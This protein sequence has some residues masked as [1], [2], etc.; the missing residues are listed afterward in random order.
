VA[1]AVTGLFATLGLVGLFLGTGEYITTFVAQYVGARRPDRIGPAVWQGVYF[2][3]AAG[4]LVAGLTP[5]V[6]HVFAFGGHEPLVQRYESQF[7]SILMLGTFPAVLMATLSTFFAGQGRTGVVLRV[8]LAVT[9][10][11]VVLDWFW[12]F[13][14]QSWPEPGVAGAAW[15][16][17][18]SQVV[19]SVLY[20]LLILLPRVHRETF[21]VVSG[22]PPDRALLLRVLRFGIPNGL[23]YSL[24]IGAFAVFM[25][26]VGRIGTTPLAASGIAFNLNMIV[27]MPMLG[28][29]IG[30]TSLVGR[31]LG[32]DRP[33]LAERV[34][35]TGFGVS[36]VYMVACGLL[37]VGV[38]HLLLAPYASRATFAGF[39]EVEAVATVLLRFIA[40]YSIF[41]MMNVVFASALRGAGDTRYPLLV[42]VGLSWGAFLLPAWWGCVHGGRGVYFAWSTATAYVV[43]LGML[44]WLR[45]RSGRW[46]RLRVIEGNEKGRHRDGGTGPDE[47][48]VVA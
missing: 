29:G 34:T 30:L 17:V 47:A 5:F 21:A 33:D 44:M 12:I 10:V 39:A 4:L 8:N 20:A 40:L 28:L 26:I 22:W 25:V 24:E 6:P 38:P 31:Y 36:L 35:R 9:A 2:A 48:T 7:A 13:G 14:H 32:A 42:T 46:K 41:D 11:N 37:Y 45:F 16:T 19:G 3:A 23:Q 27:F 18:V 15:A 1:G 43:L